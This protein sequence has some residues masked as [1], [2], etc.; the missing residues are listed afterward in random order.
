MRQLTQLADNSYTGQYAPDYV[1]PG[2][3]DIS[4]LAQK[5]TKINTTAPLAGG[6][7]LSGDRT[8]TIAAATD[9]AAGSMSAADKV[10]LDLMSTDSTV[11]ALPAGSKGM[12]TFVN[13]ALTPTFGAAVVGGGAVVV[14]VYHDG[15]SWKVG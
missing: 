6:G 15:V 12:R 14:P 3:A 13:N 1:A 7:D 10:K 9:A 5:A 8:I 2:P 11:A 4:G